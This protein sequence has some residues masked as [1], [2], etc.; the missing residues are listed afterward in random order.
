MGGAGA[1]G[2]AGARTRGGTLSTAQAGARFGSRA[3]FSGRDGAV[4]GTA[5]GTN[6]LFCKMERQI[7]GGTMK[8]TLIALATPCANHFSSYGGATTTMKWNVS[9]NR[10][11]FNF[12]MSRF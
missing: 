8:M 11:L 2:G 4:E 12:L 9:I 7:T 10:R 1:L 3:R 6:G 5:T